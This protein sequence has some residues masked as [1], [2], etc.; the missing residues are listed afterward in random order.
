MMTDGGP[1]GGVAA[2]ASLSPPATMSTLSGSGPLSSLS[3]GSLRTLLQD[4][5]RHFARADDFEDYQR[6]VFSFLAGKFGPQ[7][8][9][10]ALSRLLA[11]NEGPALVLAHNS[12][13]LHVLQLC[14]ASEQRALEALKRELGDSLAASAMSPPSTSSQAAA[15]SLKLTFSR[16]IIEAL[17]PADLHKRFLTLDD[18]RELYETKLRMKQLHGKEE[19]Q[20][21]AQRQQR[22]MRVPRLPA[23]LN[24]LQYY[25]YPVPLDILKSLPTLDYLK[26][27]LAV[28]ASSK[29]LSL[30]D[31]YEAVMSS[32]NASVPELSYSSSISKSGSLEYFLSAWTRGIDKG[33][34]AGAASTPPA[35]SVGLVDDAK[36]RR[37]A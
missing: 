8:M 12:L 15:S 32:V 3:P 9:Q 11:D 26:K 31:E 22:Q 30:F 13:I 5:R 7:Q 33:A 6:V 2:A 36:K 1:G 37:L 17:N 29:G 23:D 35:S 20:A 16:A 19:Q 10:Q 24:N 34:N 27:R 18:K 21:H 28:Q 25:N 14:D 4:V